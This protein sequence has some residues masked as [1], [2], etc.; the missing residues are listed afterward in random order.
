MS[1]GKPRRV[2]THP[3]MFS[4]PFLRE[5]V[6]PRIKDMWPDAPFGNL[7]RLWRDRHCAELNPYESQWCPYRPEECAT[8]FLLAVTNTV[9]ANPRSRTGYFRAVA[10]ST[11]LK[12]ADDKPLRR[13]ERPGDAGG[14]SGRIAPRPE[15]RSRTA[16]PNAIGDVL[17]ALDLGPREGRTQNG[18]QSH[19]RPR[20]PRR[21]VP[22]SH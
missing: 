19:E 11:A 7:R 10:L 13:E 17:G 3:C 4:T 18:P 6:D 8:A 1:S 15:V 9:I 16:R 22:G 12:R 20:P 21:P 14:I 2:S 5:Q